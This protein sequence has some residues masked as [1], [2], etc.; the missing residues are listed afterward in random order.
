MIEAY[1]EHYISGLCCPDEHVAQETD[2]LTDVEER[3]AMLQGVVLYEQ[4]DLV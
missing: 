3:Q 1:D 2:M 4:T